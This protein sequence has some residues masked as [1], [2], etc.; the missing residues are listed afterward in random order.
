MGQHPI[1]AVMVGTPVS[2]RCRLR[3]VVVVVVVETLGLTAAAEAVRGGVPDG[4]I[5]VVQ[6]RFPKVMPVAI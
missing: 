4:V 6:A 2:V 5:L 3:L 1:P